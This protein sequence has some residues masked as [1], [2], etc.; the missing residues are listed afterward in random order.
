MAELLI[1]LIDKRNY[2]SPL[3]DPQL[4]RRGDVIFIGE[5]GHG[6]GRLELSLPEYIILSLPG[7]PVLDVLDYIGREPGNRYLNPTLRY[8]AFFLDIDS[9]DWPVQFPLNR[10]I[11]PIVQFPGDTEKL[12]WFKRRRESVPHPHVLGRDPRI[13]M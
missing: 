6:W 12:S 1:R 9:V 7:V 3:L 11:N 13:I 10:E 8:R 5:D 2:S 4:S